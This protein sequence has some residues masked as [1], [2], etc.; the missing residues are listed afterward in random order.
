MSWLHVVVYSPEGAVLDWFELPV[1]IGT[2]QGMVSATVVAGQVH[3]PEDVPCRHPGCR[4]SLDV[5]EACAE[6]RALE[7]E[8]WERERAEYDGW[9]D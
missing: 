8:R 3:G 2:E 5:A 1:P 4:A 7:E 9:A 6:E